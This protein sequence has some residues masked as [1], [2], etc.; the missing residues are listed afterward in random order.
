[1]TP[2]ARAPAEPHLLK[3]F[4]FLGAAQFPHRP[5]PRVRQPFSNFKQAD[6]GEE[7]RRRSN[8]R[9]TEEGVTHRNEAHQTNKN[10]EKHTHTPS[11]QTSAFVCAAFEAP[12]HGSTTRLYILQPPASFFIYYSNKSLTVVAPQKKQK[13]GRTRKRHRATGLST[14]G[15]PRPSLY[16]LAEDQQPELRAAK[17][18]DRARVG[19][20][21]HPCRAPPATATPSGHRPCSPDPPLLGFAP[22][23]PSPVPSHTLGPTPTPRPTTAP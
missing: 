12:L 6:T 17:T 11:F 1:M 14:G 15:V 9:R 3:P 7:S 20:G 10:K 18:V 19:S 2:G 13:G 5:V 22:P 23:G 8:S 21:S 16:S 4:A